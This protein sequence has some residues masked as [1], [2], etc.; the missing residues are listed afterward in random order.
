MP[1]LTGRL[2]LRWENSRVLGEV[3]TVAADAQDRVDT[4]LQ[5]NATPGW[6]IFNLR[7][8]LSLGQWRLQLLLKNVLDHA[9]REHFSYQ[10]DPFRSGY[11][12]SEPGRSATVTLGWGM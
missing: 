3:E 1:P 9:Y 10:R 12:V 5:E 8:G 7:G 11:L 4:D 6:G 2:A